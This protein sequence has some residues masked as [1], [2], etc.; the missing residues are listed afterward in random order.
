MKKTLPKIFNLKVG[1]SSDR[2][3][4]NQGRGSGS[5]KRLNFR[6][7]GSGTTLKKEAGS[8]SKLGSI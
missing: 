4:W 2:S 3:L 5:W 8:G 6:A 7:R 1:A